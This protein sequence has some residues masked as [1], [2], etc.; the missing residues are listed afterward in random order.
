MPTGFILICHDTNVC[1]LSEVAMIDVGIAA[2]TLALDAADDGIG[3]CMIASFKKEITEVLSLPDN[4][5]PRLLM[6]FGYPAERAIICEPRDGDVTYFR[7][8][9]GLHFVPK[10]P[11]AEVAL[12]GED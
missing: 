6:A 4:L 9:S 5:S 12:T 7:D 8:D 11:L 10:R 2:Q 1:P 3:S